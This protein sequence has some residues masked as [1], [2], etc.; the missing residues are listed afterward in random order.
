MH[1]LA[2]QGGPSAYNSLMGINNSQYYKISGHVS[3][4]PFDEKMYYMACP[5][6]R[7]KVIQEVDN[8]FKCEHCGKVYD[9]A[10]PT[11]MVQG[12]FS[13]LSGSAYIS[14]T[15]ECGEAIVGKSAAELHEMKANTDVEEVKDYINSNLF[16]VRMELNG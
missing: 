3:H 10:N 9:S 15:R 16:K 1:S 11:Y 14:F 6:C 4:I 8:R 7:K 13:D 2:N 5:Q 12:K